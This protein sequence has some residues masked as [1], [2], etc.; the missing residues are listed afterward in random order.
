[1]DRIDNFLINHGGKIMFIFLITVLVL[2]LMEVRQYYIDKDEFMRECALYEK[3]YKCIAM[4][5]SNGL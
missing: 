2:L 5:R 1:M 3:Q 4:W